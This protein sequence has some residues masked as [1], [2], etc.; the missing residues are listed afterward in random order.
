ML[1]AWSAFFTM[2][3]RMDVQARRDIVEKGEL[4]QP[5]SIATYQQLVESERNTFR[6]VFFTFTNGGTYFASDIDQWTSP[7]VSPIARL[8]EQQLIR[9]Q[10]ILYNLQRAVHLRIDQHDTC[11]DADTSKAAERDVCALPWMLRKTTI[12]VCA[13]GHLAHGRHQTPHTMLKIGGDERVRLG[14]SGTGRARVEQAF[15]HLTKFSGEALT[16]ATRPCWQGAAICEADSQSREIVT[17]LPAIVLIEFG[18]RTN[19]DPIPY[20]DFVRSHSD[21]GKPN[22]T[23]QAAFERFEAVRL[24]SPPEEAMSWEISTT[25]AP[26]AATGQSK[27]DRPR[28]RLLGRINATSAAGIHYHCAF[29][30]Q[31]GTLWRH[32]GQKDKGL[33]QKVTTSSDSSAWLAQPSEHL[34]LLCYVCEDLSLLQKWNQERVNR[35]RAV[36]YCAPESTSFDVHGESPQGDLLTPIPDEDRPWLDERCDMRRQREYR[37]SLPVTSDALSVLKG[38]VR[39]KRTVPRG[40]TVAVDTLDLTADDPAP[41]PVARRVEHGPSAGSASKLRNSQAP[42][43]TPPRKDAAAATPQARRHPKNTY[44]TRS[45]SRLASTLLQTIPEVRDGDAADHDQDLVLEDDG[46][47]P[48]S[49]R[50]KP[51]RQLGAIAASDD[52]PTLK[53][54]LDRADNLKELLALSPTRDS[55][56]R[57]D[58][59]AS[60]IAE[61]NPLLPP[62]R[63]GSRSPRALAAAREIA[64]PQ[65]NVTATAPSITPVTAQ[66][67][68]AIFRPSKRTA[69]KTP[70][71]RI[72]SVAQQTQPEDP[73]VAVC[74]PL[75][76]AEQST[77]TTDRSAHSWQNTR[78]NETRPVP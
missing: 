33:P 24:L 49:V 64:A 72:K 73:E 58:S 74:L 21:N 67:K 26:A 44:G 30:D 41:S 70:A 51:K 29:V 69:Q 10:T 43:A 46:A 14:D 56:A 71:S 59:N 34:Q 68:P 4:D 22:K 57:D 11:T 40:T 42:N 38:E 7:Q 3:T 35:I 2:R 39:Y 5:V 17:S 37:H 77:K 47:G 6:R 62:T 19:P 52:S 12:S 36:F 9:R 65:A 28:Y 13:G 31:N 75:G 25:I 55:A 60:N 1:E 78:K 61:Q 16:K 23:V 15:E 63:A 45:A 20:D 27:A 18:P 66:A 53:G 8:L 50:E 32:D 54:R 48:E 76:L